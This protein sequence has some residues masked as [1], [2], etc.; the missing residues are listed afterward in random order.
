MSRAVKLPFK[1]FDYVLHRQKRVRSHGA[2]QISY[3]ISFRR[4]EVSNLK[5]LIDGLV[6][7][8]LSSF[9]SFSLQFLLFYERRKTLVYVYEIVWNKNTK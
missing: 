4:R 5:F 1:G 7:Q 2:A 6:D 3:V 9:N 8:L